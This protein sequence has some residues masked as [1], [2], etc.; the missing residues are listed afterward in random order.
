VLRVLQPKK[1]DTW[2]EED[3]DMVTTSQILALDVGSRRIGVA[4]ADS[5]SRIAYPLKTIDVDGE[6]L[7]TIS[8]LI[9]ENHPMVLVVGYPR[10]QSGEPT[11]QTEFVEAFAAKLRP[12]DVPIVF[13]DESLTSVMAEER[14]KNQGGT[15]TKADIDSM[16]ATIILTDY[17]EAN[18]G[19]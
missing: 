15:Y 11:A 16:A 8:K 10:N 6:E 3:F 13:Q 4:Q 9:T 17:L 2:P 14:L 5:V 7:R 18:H 19:H 12:C 1:V